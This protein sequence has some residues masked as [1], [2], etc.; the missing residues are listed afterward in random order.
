LALVCD[1]ILPNYLGFE[2]LGIMFR[3]TKTNALFSIVQTF[4]D[5]ENKLMEIIR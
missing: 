2:G 4:N 1:E 3:D 5:D